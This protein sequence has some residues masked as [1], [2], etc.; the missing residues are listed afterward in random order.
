MPMSPR[1]NYLRAAR[2]EGPEWI[3]A[4]VHISP[5]SWQHLRNEAEAVC[6]RHPLLFPGFR[7]GQIDF[8]R[9]TFRPHQRAGRPYRDAW[10]CVWRTTM[11]GI[12]GEVVEHPLADWSAFESFEPPDSLTSNDHIETP[13]WEEV[14]ARFERRRAAGE[15]CGGGLPHGHFFMR[16]Y[17]LRGFENLMLDIATGDPRLDAL[18]EMVAAHNA[19]KVDQWL[20]LGPDVLHFPEDLGTQ[21]ASMISPSHFARYVTPVYHRL[22]APARRAGVLVHVHSDGHVVE[23]ADELIAAGADIVNPQDLC[24]G[25]D[26]L[27]R[28]FKGRVCIDL[29]VDRQ[30][31]VPFGSPAEIRE[32]IE[33]EVRTLGSPA[34]G[35]MLTVGIYPPTPPENLE[36]VC[37]AFEALQTDGSG[38]S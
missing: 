2:F 33:Q 37:A 29:D 21:S 7:K 26:D 5:A 32:L 1:E 18:I 10:G 20:S 31:V 23:L 4:R 6:A 13:V 35:L 28:A 3:P 9:M 11:D 12:T 15:L 24:N 36:A 30:S 16:L 17:Y 22:M 27:R 19:A 14:A 8:D 38:R 34:G 25:L